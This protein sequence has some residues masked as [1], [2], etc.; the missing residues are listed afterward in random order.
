MTHTRPAAHPVT[1][2]TCIEGC[3]PRK[4][5]NIRAAISDSRNPIPKMSAGLCARKCS[6]KRGWVCHPS[7]K[8]NGAY[9]IPP[10]TNATVAATS[11][12]NKFIPAINS[13]LVCGPAWPRGSGMQAKTRPPPQ[14]AG[15]HL[16]TLDLFKYEL[17]EVAPVGPFGQV[18]LCLKQE[19]FHG[20]D[21]G[22]EVVGEG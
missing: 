17:V 3:G 7:P 5:A 18:Q 21:P 16:A 15:V 9:Q 11:T 1:T 14:R 13:L 4:I 22:I 8:S 6:C 2:A 19:L 12:A 20:V 10:T